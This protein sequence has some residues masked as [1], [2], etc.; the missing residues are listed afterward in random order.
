MLRKIG[1][2][3]PNVITTSPD[4]IDDVPGKNILRF[5]DRQSRSDIRA[6]FAEELKNASSE[7]SAFGKRVGRC[8]RG[9]RSLAEEFRAGLVSAKWKVG[10]DEEMR[11][12]LISFT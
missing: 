4:L 11:E 5:N 9:K 10:A 7:T 8:R 1:T 2:A 12:D 6:Q 3:V